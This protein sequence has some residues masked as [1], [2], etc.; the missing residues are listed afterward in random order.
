MAERVCARGSKV[1]THPTDKHEIA[2]AYD[3]WA[4]TYDTDP[5]R[6]RELA[7]AALRQRGSE[8]ARRDVIEVGCG[9]GRNTQW[10]AERARSVTALDF[11]EGMLR[12]AK[13]RVRPPLA[14]FLHHDIRSAWPLADSSADL[15]IVM[16]VPEHIENLGP[17][18]AEAVRTLRSGGEMFLCELH[19]MRQ[20]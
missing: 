8:L 1:M 20:M 2:A 18:F 3:L 7:S 14:R 9:T 16:L 17:V 4:D 13:A 15:V 12:Q 11:S 19:P 6:T 10:L 5:N